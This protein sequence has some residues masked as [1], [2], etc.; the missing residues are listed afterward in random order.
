MTLPELVT[1]LTTS[2]NNFGPI[3]MGS[4]P[5]TPNTMGAIY[6]YGGSQAMAGFGYPGVQ[7]ENPSVQL[8]FRG[9]PGDY[10]APR[11]KAE[12]AYRAMAQIQA[13]VLSGTK[14]LFV[15]PN[16]SPFLLTR[17]E[18]DCVL[19]ACNFSVTKELS[20]S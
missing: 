10:L 2:P 3:T 19:I 4:M 7:H 12:A 1:Y 20:A 13:K 11:Q 9:E 15:S 17:D 5:A 8:V 14:Y 16:Q 6:E 18:N